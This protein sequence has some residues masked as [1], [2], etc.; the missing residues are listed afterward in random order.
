MRRTQGIRGEYLGR[1]RKREYLYFLFVSNVRRML[2]IWAYWIGVV[3]IVS[4]ILASDDGRLFFNVIMD[5]RYISLL[6]IIVFISITLF[7]HY[8]LQRIKNKKIKLT[9]SSAKF[10]IT[11]NRRFITFFAVL[12]FTCITGMFNISN[13]FTDSLSVT[14]IVV[15]FCLYFI[16]LF[17]IVI[18]IYK[19]FNIYRY[20]SR[21]T[22]SLSK[23]L[24]EFISSSPTEIDPFILRNEGV[25]IESLIISVIWLL[26]LVVLRES[27]LFS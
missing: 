25:I 4:S 10:I 11:S 2:D 3:S 26:F 5:L 19:C 18:S 14:Y 27:Y 7:S 22:E 15:L 13:K 21:L 1:V 9:P 20:S 17:G 12:F 24:K 16:F 6:T 23:D 8:S